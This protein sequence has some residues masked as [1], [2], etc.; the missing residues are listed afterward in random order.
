MSIVQNIPSNGLRAA[1]RL[2]FGNLAVT[3][4]IAGAEAFLIVAAAVLSGA[5]Y[6]YAAYG[7]VGS[8]AGYSAFGMLAA[9]F[10]ILPFAG[11]GESALGA[12]LAGGRP[13][14]QIVLRWHVAFLLI[15]L[16][17]FL[18]K[19]TD[20]FSRGWIALFFLIGLFSLLRLERTAARAVRSAVDRGVVRARRLML[21]G[22]EE[23]LAAYRA[24]R[25]GEGQNDQL[26]AVLRLAPDQLGEDAASRAAL[27]AALRSASVDARNQAVDD[28]LLLPSVRRGPV[29][30][31]CL[32]CF[33][34]L[35]VG[36]HLDAFSDIEAIG[37][38]RIETVGPIIALTLSAAP[39]RPVA[40]IGKRF[41]D[42]VSSSLA[43]VALSPLF[44]IVAALIK[45]DSAGPVLFRQ[46]RR[47]YNHR[48]FAIYKFRTMTTLDDG[49]RVEQARVNDPRVTRVGRFL[50]RWSI[51]ELPQLLNVLKGEMSIVGPR[52]H[53]VAHDRL[54]ETRIDR[55]ARR[56]NVKPGI[57][58]WAQVNGLR[59][60]TDTDEKM[61]NRVGHD[62]YYID[63]WS[64]PFDL[65][66]IVLTVTSPR[67]FSNAH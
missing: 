1:Q 13:L 35:P 25:T 41:F 18:T 31:A 38:P 7:E 8:L 61:R 43:L 9:L 30:N 23:D 42:I 10:F 40:V 66:I 47:G 24:K 5:G 34:L 27:A 53:A 54:F 20:T 62:L 57:T 29:L 58:G 39:A 56:L 33:A 22:T 21:V 67:A 3:C 28:V 2:T 12:R 55:Y 52:P 19:T 49:D 37:Q 32:D 44:L 63:N 36:I 65:Y 60:E 11:R 45:L 50:R 46:R 64:L 16:V 15:A 26:V 48:E 51:D 4:A 14:Q 17:G 59:G 6:H